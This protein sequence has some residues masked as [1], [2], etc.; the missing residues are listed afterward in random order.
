M[1]ISQ[2][3]PIFIRFQLHFAGHE[4]TVN[5]VGNEWTDLIVNNVA[6]LVVFRIF[7]GAVS[8]GLIGFALSKLILFVKHQ[9]PHF[10]VPQVCLA[11]EIIA[12]MCK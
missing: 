9:G 5:I 2:L 7:F 4:V 6:T 8:T 1:K 12:N 10:N 11:L 3:L